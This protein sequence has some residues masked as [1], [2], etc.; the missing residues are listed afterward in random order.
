[1]GVG[2]FSSES[3]TDK[4]SIDNKIAVSDQGI[5]FAPK[6]SNNS[7]I[8]LGKGAQ[9]SINNGASLDDIKAAVGALQNG[10]AG[11]GQRVTSPQN[12]VDQVITDRIE[13]NEAAADEE[14]AVNSTKFNWKVI[15]GVV[16]IVA[17]IALF[18]V[19][20]RTR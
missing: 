13:D 16:A 3:K 8:K 15:G 10:G 7:N 14:I 20:R 4:K 2:A 1:M 18:T 11:I 6:K 5:A 12:A 19:W 17:L 9:L